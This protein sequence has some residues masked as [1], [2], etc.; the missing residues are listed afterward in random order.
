M[1][2]ENHINVNRFFPSHKDRLRGHIDVAFR[3]IRTQK[4]R[5]ILTLL[6]VVIGVSSVIG[7]ASIIEGLNKDVVGRIQMMGSKVF[8]V[9]RVGPQF[10]RPSQ[11]IR[12]RKY[13][14]SSDA[15]AI[16]ESAP[17]VEFVTVF[18]DRRRISSGSNEIRYRNR[19]VNGFFLRG[20]DEFHSDTITAMDVVQGRPI[21]LQDRKHSRNVAV[22]GRAI[23]ESLFPFTDPIGHTVRFNGLPFEVVGIFVRDEGLF[24][25]PGIDQ[26]VTI[27]L[28]T[29][30]KLYPNQREHFIAASVR[31]TSQIS[32]A[33][34]ETVSALRRVRKVPALRENDFEVFMPEFFAR[35][36]KQVTSALFLLTF[37]ISSIALV[38]GGIGVM[39]IMLVSV[40]QRTQ[41][42]GVRK[43]VGA[44]A[45]DIRMQFLIEA[46]MLTCLG[47]I[48]GIL[49]G[50]SIAW[51]VKLV[52]PIL[53]VAVS[54]VWVS[55]AFTISV[56][57]GLFFGYYPANRAASLDP[58]DCLRYE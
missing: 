40:T 1:S 31:D 18:A 52:Y 48:V 14:K 47:G 20:V 12:Q 49:F 17:T 51:G 53:P 39:N 5:S 43:A 23:A 56:G 36:W 7:V 50:L 29:F 4:T 11:E 15:Q 13:L 21:S 19:H 58:I 2:P 42:I 3:S 35:I 6:G 44:R 26:M 33:V 32:Q 38:V 34:D 46:I 45:Q 16:R 30:H 22:L 8:I 10:G 41:E 54:L 9:G 27:P 55:V 24:G 57:I 25:A 28:S 37:S